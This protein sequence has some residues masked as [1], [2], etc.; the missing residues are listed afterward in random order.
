[1]TN[2]LVR[3][4][5][6]I[7][8]FI[9][10]LG[11]LVLNPIISHLPGWLSNT[12]ISIGLAFI[13][14]LIFKYTSNQPAITRLKDNIKANMLAIKLFKDSI[15]VILQAQLRTFK[16]SLFLLL[17]SLIPMFVMIIPFTLLLAQLSMYYQARPLKVGE[18]TLVTMQLN[19]Q[20]D[21]AWPNVTLQPLSTEVTLG[22]VRIFSK[23]QLCWK[24]KALKNGHHLL[25]FQV[26][27]QKFDKTLTIGDGYT[28]LSAK[29]PGQKWSDILQYP[30]EKPFGQNSVV[31]SLTIDYPPRRSLTSG[32]NWWF[33]YLF[34]TSFVFAFIFK[35]FLKVKI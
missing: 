30:A 12:I 35:P 19:D 21:A 31:Q 16:A 11:K 32:T 17:N 3:I 22:P 10:F 25:S 9:N 27:N 8:I 33:I 28:L 5:V 15:A 1:M 29:R 2:I 23:R 20:I 7:N 6:S 13:I 26:D 34:I 24:I 14:L 4:I 18:E